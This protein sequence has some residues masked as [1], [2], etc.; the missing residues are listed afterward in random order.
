MTDDSDGVPTH[1]QG[2]LRARRGQP[3]N[4]GS[5]FAA[6]FWHTNTVE[7]YF[8]ILKRGI[9]GHLSPRQPAALEAL[10]R[11]VRFPLRIRMGLGPS[12]TRNATLVKKR[13][14]GSPLS[15][16]PIGGL[17]GPKKPKARAP[18]PIW[19]DGTEYREPLQLEFNFMI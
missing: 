12:M 16:S 3:L 19:P 13:R 11:R 8:S 7:N 10:S 9:H 14:R 15:A 1:R 4:R 6:K 2:L 17:V 18:K 5:T